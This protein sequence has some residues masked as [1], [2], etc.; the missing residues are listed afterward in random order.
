M[1][2]NGPP[3]GLRCAVNCVPKDM[4][5]QECCTKDDSRSITTGLS[6]WRRCSLHNV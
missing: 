1:G 5:V 4:K 6:V 3:T 2:K